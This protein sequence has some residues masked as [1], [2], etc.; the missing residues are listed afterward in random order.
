V[1]ATW[2]CGGVTYR[3]ACPECGRFI[4]PDDGAP[5]GFC[6]THGPVRMP[7]IMPDAPRK[8]PFEDYLA[9]DA[10]NWS[11]LRHMDASPAH[12]RHRELEPPPDTPRLA[13]GRAA[14]TAVLEPEVF[15]ERYAVFDGARRAGKAFDEFEEANIG[16]TILRRDEYDTCMAVRDAVC[17]HEVAASLL[18]G[19]SEL[20]YEWTDPDTGIACKARLDHVNAD[21]GLIELKTTSSVDGRTFELLSARML[22]HCQLAFYMRALGGGP[23]PTI[24]AV[25]IEPPH[26]VAVFELT[27]EALCV[28][29]AR[30]SELLD[31]LATC[32]KTDE[33]PGRYTET[34]ELSLPPWMMPDDEAFGMTIG[35]D[36]I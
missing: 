23:L 34:Q 10:V 16:L 7:R 30:V 17:A 14:H 35:G 13:L 27:E 4:P 22:Y 29:D 15:D 31:Q 19:S 20:V 28:G 32:R 21:G 6:A 25:E 11:L 2:T 12:Y 18:Y 1:T 8:M 24:I 26:D 3:R 9:I 33:W 5:T 36:S